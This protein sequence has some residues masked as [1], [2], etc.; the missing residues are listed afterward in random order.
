MSET[1]LVRQTSC[2]RHRGDHRLTVEQL[3]QTLWD[4]AFGIGRNVLDAL[5]SEVSESGKGGKSR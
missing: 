1:K 2:L 4:L 5:A 3:G